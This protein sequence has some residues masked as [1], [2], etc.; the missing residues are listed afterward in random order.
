MGEIKKT[1][2]NQLNLPEHFDPSVGKLS[3][4]MELIDKLL[5]RA[6]PDG[7]TYSDNSAITDLDTLFDIGN[8]VVSPDANNNPFGAPAYVTVQ[9][10]SSGYN[11]G[12]CI[13]EINCLPYTDKRAR[14]GVYYYNDTYNTWIPSWGEWY[15]IPT[16]VNQGHLSGLDSDKVDGLHSSD[17]FRTYLNSNTSTKEDFNSL[18]AIGFHSRIFAVDNT[19]T[20][21]EGWWGCLVLP[22]HP[23]LSTSV[24]QIAFEHSAINPDYIMYIRRRT[25]SGIWTAWNTM[26]GSGNDGDS[27]G[28]DADLLDGS[29]KRDFLLKKDS[30]FDFV[31]ASMD[32]WVYMTNMTN[33]GGYKRIGI[34]CNIGGSVNWNTDALDIVIPSNVTLIGSVASSFDSY[35]HSDLTH[36][37]WCRSLKGHSGCTIQGLEICLDV[38]ANYNNT[39]TSDVYCMSD[40]G[41]VNNCNISIGN[42]Y[43]KNNYIA[44]DDTGR[45]YGLYNCSRVYHTII[46]DSGH[47]TSAS[48]YSN[49]TY[50]ANSEQLSDVTVK[51][52]NGAYNRESLVGFYNCDSLVSCTFV[53]RANNNYTNY[54][55][56]FS[57]FYKCY[58]LTNCSIRVGK[59][60]SD[61]SYILKN[62]TLLNS[63]DNINGLTVEYVS[64]GE[65]ILTF[66]IKRC[67]NILSYKETGVSLKFEECSEAYTPILSG[68]ETEENPL[69][70]SPDTDYPCWI[71]QGYVAIKDPYT[72]IVSEPTY[73]NSTLLLNIT[74]SQ[75]QLQLSCLT[76]SEYEGASLAQIKT[77]F[78]SGDFE[79]MTSS[80]DPDTLVENILK[81]DK[82]F[83]PKV[84]NSDTYY[85]FNELKEAG[86]YTGYFSDADSPISGSGASRWSCLVINTDPT[87]DHSEEYLVQ[88]AFRS[89]ETPT[90]YPTYVRDYSI[91]RGGWGSWRALIDSESQIDAK[92]LAGSS[93]LDY[94]YVS[95][96]PCKSGVYTLYTSEITGVSC[97]YGVTQ[98]Y[99]D[100]S[101]Y[102]ITAVDMSGGKVYV[103]TSGHPSWS[104][105]TPKI[106]V[107][108]SDPTSPSDGQ[109]WVVTT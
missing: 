1:N 4:N 62:N 108:T 109:I 23:T 96:L 101:N 85:F 63:C 93:P 2:F 8:Y 58:N 97:C 94:S 37:V 79:V 100:S 102:S 76:S 49:T 3:E 91:K 99:R 59:K 107:L 52:W 83:L 86:L 57:G 55:A 40:F 65:D 16:S 29:H 18:T 64:D 73:M 56:I 103:K 28:L 30:Y 13:Q 44:P 74:G 87:S 33:W 105:I 12:Y 81:A 104:E 48:G 98:I 72:G 50:I 82:S 68:G 14:L 77:D 6:L 90:S 46:S 66:I 38:E 80:S 67:S 88:L 78:N 32:D 9:G 27:S 15:K 41:V 70:V 89:D 10:C 61:Y 35:T 42:H 106:E 53:L 19:P 84:N 69:I 39:L 22:T 45:I 95:S 34:A 54:N 21:I 92:Y 20:W 5:Y 25:T 47:A 26:W 71:K 43:N 31:V 60:G 7:A 17:L 75:G 36:R 11:S 51:A 24:V